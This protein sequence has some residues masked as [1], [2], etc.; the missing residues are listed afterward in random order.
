AN[1][2]IDRLN[3]D[4]YLALGSSKKTQAGRTKRPAKSSVK[5]GS[6][7]APPSKPA[8][9]PLA[10][11]TV[12]GAFDANLRARIKSLTFGGMPISDLRFE[13]TAHN[14]RFQLRDL[15]AASVAGLAFRTSGQLVNL[16]PAA[17]PR[18]E[19]VKFQMKTGN[20]VRFLKAAGVNY[21]PRRRSPM[22]FSLSGAASGNGLGLQIANL[23][24]RIGKL[25]LQGT[26]GLD[27]TG[28]RPRINA[29]IS[30]SS[31]ILEDF[32]P[33]ET[34]A[35]KGNT[36]KRSRTRQSGR[37]TGKSPAG[38]APSGAPVWSNDPINLSGLAGVDAD[39]KL[40]SKS[41]LF[42]KYRLRDARLEALL[43]GGKL[44]ARRLSGRLFGGDLNVQVQLAS[45]DPSPLYQ[46]HLSLKGMDV[47]SA[48]RALAKQKLKSGKM[49]LTAD[50]TSS[51]TSQAALV[52]ALK[53][54]G[55]LSI[56][57]LDIDARSVGGTA[58]A[59]ALVLM[60]SFNQLAGKL[61]GNRKKGLADLTGSF[62]MRRGIARSGDLK[63]VSTLGR[64]TA[65][66]VVDL[67]KWWI[68]AEGDVRLAGNLLVRLLDRKAKSQ[69]VLPFSLRGPL[70]N[71]KPILETGKMPGRGI[72]I[73]GL[74]RLRRKKGVGAVINQIFPGKPPDAQ[75]APAPAAKP[76]PGEPPP[77][78]PPPASPEPRKKAKPKDILKNLILRG[79]GG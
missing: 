9:D 61:G 31:I 45:R 11:L 46:A 75:A 29:D 79:L 47:P 1:L 5:A 57:R 36:Q 28:P 43:V 10:V 21:R 74:D 77:L 23:R 38:R 4:G 37:S 42:D 15:S 6:Q 68:D 14:G 50:L 71:P 63:L 67:P 19:N 17:T 25:S 18:I 65:K 53:G 72:V 64:G 16:A 62:Q 69:R 13:G 35:G 30:T 2:A 66:G 33:P 60:S 44:D 55:N 41:V 70:D 48:L 12:L 34:R 27:F 22:V 51:G 26:G 73:P 32:L 52:G 56:S 8:D 59:P 76:A 3:L 20:F 54:Q 24:G 39:I 49:D 7:T 78:S 58:F 40:Q